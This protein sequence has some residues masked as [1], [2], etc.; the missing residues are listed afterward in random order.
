MVRRCPLFV[1][2]L[3]F[4]GVP[5][6]A[7]DIDPIKVALLVDGMVSRGSGYDASE[8]H[9]Q[10]V[11]GLAAVLD[12]LLP[13]TAPPAAPLPVGPPENEIRRLIARLDA[14][15]FKV[16]EAATEELIAKARGRKP[17][18][19]EALNSQSTEIQFRAARILA[20]WE[21]RPAT[22]LSAYLSGFWAYVEDIG[23]RERLVLL[24]RRTLK[25]FE[26]GMPEGDRLHLLRLCIAGVAHGRDDASC[27]I[28]R[29]LVRHRDVRIATLV[30]ET[31]GAY[32]T[33]P[34]FVPELLVD[35]LGS[36]QKS[37]VEAALRFVVGCQDDRRRAQVRQALGAVFRQSDESLKFQAC[38]PLMRD[39]HDSDAWLYVLEQVK[40]ND[41]NR[42]RTALNWIGDTKNCGQAPDGR[43]LQG[44]E[45]LLAAGGDER[46]VAVQALG[47]FAGEAVARRLI[48]FLDDSDPNVAR[49]ADAGLL[50]Q[51]DREL[52]KRLLTETASAAASGVR[53]RAQTL[54]TRIQQP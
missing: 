20:S 35:A 5:A 21:S 44:M 46:R 7:A 22:R 30:T 14:D 19:E 52:V 36:D 8:L 47:T 48:G 3:M 26:Q 11:E 24:A 41:A 33:E 42:V 43:F 29:P 16:R 9:A 50:A 18:I 40:G 37:V 51:P 10:G 27:E 4:C 34:R 28:L 31:T 53:S 17:L 49:Q 12:H 38:L 13:D 1:V 25:A 2:A 6:G 45:R 54:L 15:E 23:D 39:F 32:K